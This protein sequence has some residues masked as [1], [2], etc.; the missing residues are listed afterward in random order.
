MAD[1]KVTLNFNDKSEADLLKLVAELAASRKLGTVTTNLIRLA[2]D[3][4]EL[5]GDDILK[6]CGII[7]KARKELIADFEQKYEVLEKKLD[8]ME[9]M[10]EKM[11][12]MAEIGK[13]IGLSDRSKNVMQALFMAEAELKQLD[14]I[15]FTVDR[16]KELVS[17]EEKCT[18]TMV[19]I[20]NS[21]D[22][23]L[24]ELASNMVVNTVSIVHD[25]VSPSVDEK[26]REVVTKQEVV[27]KE[28]IKMNIDNT[29]STE[30]NINDSTGAEL[31]DMSDLLAFMGM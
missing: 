16:H 9:T 17:L 11:Y 5:L 22:N 6:R 1:Y 30:E 27:Y 29:V 23:I 18:D 21:Y 14:T 10:V 25:E 7:T 24:N 26:P 15:G 4:P 12:T 2:Y 28:P 31:E 20:L 8:K 13:R 19:F 3:N